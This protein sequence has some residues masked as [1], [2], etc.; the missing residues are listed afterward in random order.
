MPAR[1][2]GAATRA[3]PSVSP[4]IDTVATNR[5]ILQWYRD[6]QRDLA[7][8]KP[9]T[10]PWGVLVSETMLQ[11]TPVARVEPEW[12]AWMARWP[13]PADLAKAPAAEVIRAWGRM[14]YPRRALRLHESAKMIVERF[15]GEVPT[16][17]EELRELPGVGDYTAS[18]VLAFAYGRRAVVLDTN[19]RRVFARLQGEPDAKSS[20][21]TA[22]EREFGQ[23]LLPRQSAR[24]ATW[25]V[26]VMELGS[27]VCTARSPQCEVCPVAQHCGWFAKGEP[28]PAGPSRKPQKYEGSDRQVRGLIMHELRDSQKPVPLSKLKTLWRDENQLTRCLASLIEDDLVEQSGKQKYRLPN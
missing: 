10:T 14:G 13:E 28:L 12:I 7:W 23:A 8:R 15:D 6:K 25:S 2:V 5:Q 4:E 3:K 27:L 22:V 9:G 18:A 16:T 26:A 11:Q 21:P 24:A 20:A 1:A 19:V 17:Y